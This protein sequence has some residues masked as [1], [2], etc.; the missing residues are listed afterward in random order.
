MHSFASSRLFAYGT[1]MFP[2]VFEAIC[3]LTRPH[4]AACL[5]GY[6]RF[7][8]Q[9]HVFQ[10]IVPN[11]HANVHGRLIDGIDGGLWHRLDA[12][13]SEIYERL[14]VSVIASNGRRE[15]A[16]TYVVAPANRDILA[17]R[18][19]SPAHFQRYE[20]SHYLARCA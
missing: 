1:L 20:L 3:K 9:D 16:Q 10:G 4:D 12:F 2:Q 18:A 11:P 14:V 6:A 8:V 19:W 15:Q 13:E 5:H 17:A 7:Q